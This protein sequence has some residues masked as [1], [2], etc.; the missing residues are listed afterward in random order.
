VRAL[1]AAGGEALYVHLDVTREEDWAHAIGATVDRFGSLDILVNNAGI[2]HGKAM[3]D[4]SLAEWHRLCG[5]NLTGVFL[6]T[7]AALPALRARGEKGAHGSAI[8]N[9]SSIAGLVGSQMDPLYSMTKGG[10]LLFT[11]SCALEFSRKGYRVRVNAV[12]PGLIETDMGTQA[13]A[14]R[15]RVLGTNDL[16]A[17]R[18]RFLDSHPIGRLGAAGDI[19]KGIL[20]L[21]SDDSG[22]MTG[23][24]LVIDGGYTA[25]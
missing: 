20:F 4:T 14:A 12:H 11:K 9:L 18:K 10:V 23:S 15:A 3:E 21:A 17:M 24:S 6:G 22:F 19:A 1:E 8:V 7:K 25:Q 16:E 2:L 13:M 5:V